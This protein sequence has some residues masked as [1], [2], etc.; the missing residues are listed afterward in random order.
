[1]L[2]APH[3]TQVCCIIFLTFQS[4]IAVISGNL[5]QQ[6]QEQTKSINNFNH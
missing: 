6:Q 4:T 1:M 3:A 5:Q 2:L